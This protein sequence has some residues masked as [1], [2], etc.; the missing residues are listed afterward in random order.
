MDYWMNGLMDY[1]GGVS[2]GRGRSIVRQSTNPSAPLRVNSDCHGRGYLIGEG[3]P[4]RSKA[5][6]FS[7]GRN[8]NTQS[9]PAKKQTKSSS[10]PPTTASAAPGPAPT[11]VVIPPA[12]AKRAPAPAPAKASTTA[13]KAVK[14][15]RANGAS[16]KTAA[17]LKAPARPAAKKAA[18]AAVT[19]AP[20]VAVT[21]K[22]APARKKATTAIATATAQLPP[23]TFEEISLRAYFIAEKRQQEGRWADPSDDWVQAERQL[24]AERGQA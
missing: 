10:K 23:P 12:T 21:T 3:C 6:A 11:P 20:A 5:E 4:R 7:P 13:P 18:P 19:P 16:P 15:V 1:C 2:L 24:L 9:M 22:R 8:E 14:A 17:P